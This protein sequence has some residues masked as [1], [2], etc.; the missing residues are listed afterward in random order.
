[1]A[2]PRKSYLVVGGQGIRIARRRTRSLKEAKAAAD[3]WKDWGGHVVDE[4]NELVYPELFAWPRGRGAVTRYYVAKT[5]TRPRAEEPPPT[6]RN[7][8]VVAP[9]EDDEPVTLRREQLPRQAGFV[10][11]GAMGMVAAVGVGFV[12]GVKLNRSLK[13]VTPMRLYPSTMG[14]VIG[15]VLAA[16]AHGSGFRGTSRAALAGA[17][18][19]AA[20]T[21]A[22]HTTRR[23]A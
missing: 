23:A 10:R 17:V 16:V 2:G 21:A 4:H 15:G 18:G 22:E 5:P 9:P 6:E 11:V 19:C 1:M 8:V 12:V 3:R 14:A 13:P 7:P 20:A